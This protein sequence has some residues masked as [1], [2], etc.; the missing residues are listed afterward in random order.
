MPVILHWLRVVVVVPESATSTGGMPP[1]PS[2]L[3]WRPSWCAFVAFADQCCSSGID[4]LHWFAWGWTPSPIL[5][6]RVGPTK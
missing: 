1:W 4:P 6:I 2:L 5:A 3:S